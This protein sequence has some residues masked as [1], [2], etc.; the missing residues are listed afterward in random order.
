MA[1]FKISIFKHQ[2]RRDDKYPVSIRVGWHKQY[3]YIGTEYYV[4]EKQINKKTF[5]LKDVFIINE[6]NRRIAKF[7]DIKSKKLGYKIE[8][9]SAKELAKYFIEE[10][11]PGTDSNINFISFSRSYIEGIKAK[12]RKSSAA[13]MSRT[14]NAVVDFCNGRD[15]VFITEITAKF[16]QQFETFLQSERTLKRNNQFGNI[17]T[18]R[19]KGLGD[20][21]IYDYMNDIRVLFNAATDEFNDE[22]KNEIRIAHYPFRKYK[23]KQ[24]PDNERRN[25]QKEQIQAIRDITGENLNLQRPCFSRDMFMLSFYL[26][27]ANF[28]DLFEMDKYSAGRISY[29]RSKTKGR[30][31]DKAFISI[32][33][34]PE[35]LPLIEK[36]KDK[37]GKKVFD[38]YQRYSDSHTFSSNV[39]KGLKIVAKFCEIDEPLS[40]YYARHT[41]AT[42]ARNKCNISKDDVD[43]ALNHID[44]S[45]KMADVYIEK[46]WSLVDNANRAV[47]DYIKI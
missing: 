20:V 19:K 8:M 42:I 23:L 46:D 27:G 40:T 30:R 36:Y 31:R 43:L 45:N 29:E 1:T 9:Y 44:Q 14:I 33:V 18:T 3:S 17:V 6:L 26:A 22:D 5:E 13:N 34:E 37:T 28:V 11:K 2:K 39:N 38:F 4:T 7:E 10:S 15:K 21:S 25:L 24:R 35:V 32:K 12:G 16:L 41:W 47:L